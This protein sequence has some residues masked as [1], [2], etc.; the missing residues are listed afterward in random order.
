[1]HRLAAALA[2]AACSAALAQQYQAH[3][4]PALSQYGIPESYLSG[5]NVHGVA[6]GFMTYTTQDANGNYHTTYHGFAWTPDTGPVVHPTPS[7]YSAINDRGDIV[8]GGTIYFSDGGVGS[9]E[10]V[11]GDLSVYGSAINNTGAVAGTSTFRYYGGCR[12]ARRAVM[13]TLS[14]GTVNLESFVPAAEVGRDI[15]DANHVVGA[16]T[17]S[18]SCGDF[19][20][21]LYRADQNQWI[22]LHA[23]LTG[24]GPGITE[25]YA[26]NG[27][28][29]VVGEGWNGSFGSAWLWDEFEGFT[30]LPALKNG[31]RDRVT[32]YDL[33]SAETVVGS[34]AID[35]WTNRHAFIWDAA[36]GMRDLNDLVELPA[37]F[38][39]DRAIAINEHGMIVGDGHWGPGWGPGVAFALVPIAA[40]CPADFNGD[41]VVNTLDLLAFLNAFTAGDASAD[42]NG[43]GTVNTLD[44]LAFLNAFTAGC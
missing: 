12:Y 9:M 22:D 34:A 17:Y 10:P 25:A 4:I 39:L 38:I 37:G 11:P 42:F 23:M 44:V 19:E 8:A 7:S 21:F 28:G 32:P 14:G 13:W 5:V 18:G 31:D 30:F 35:G 2:M 27:E 33:N 20:A 41:G 29:Q 26:V 15:N 24:G 16:A 43:D 3:I 6:V 40:P 36:N 1:M